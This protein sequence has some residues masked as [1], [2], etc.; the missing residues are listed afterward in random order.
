MFEIDSVNGLFSWFL[1]ISAYSVSKRDL[2]KQGLLVSSYSLLGQETARHLFQ[3][4]SVVPSMTWFHFSNTP[5]DKAL[6]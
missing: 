3:L 4:L 5:L 1:D 6:T 2:L